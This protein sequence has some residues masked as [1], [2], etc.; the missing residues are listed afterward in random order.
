MRTV[1]V[2]VY[3]RNPHKS[4]KRRKARRHNPH[5]RSA[6]RA[7]RKHTHYGKVRAHK[8]RVNPMHSRKRRTHRRH[9][10]MSSLKSA[11]GLKSIGRVLA[12]GGGFILGNQAIKLASAGTFFGKALFTPPAMLST[13]LR[14]GVGLLNIVVGSFIAKKAKG[15]VAQDVAL[16]F[17]VAGGVD[18]IVSLVNKASPGLLGVYVNDPLSAFRTPGALGTIVSTRPNTLGG[19]PIPSRQMFLSGARRGGSMTMSSSFDDEDSSFSK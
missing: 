9:N 14:P 7:M 17:I 2:R 4:M 15:A 1:K 11:I 12:I 18:V 8:R 16:G 3:R 10:P 13:T 5:K 6:A 19:I